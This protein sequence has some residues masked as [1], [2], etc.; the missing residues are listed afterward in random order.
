M[1]E[2]VFMVQMI[3]FR[4]LKEDLAGRHRDRPAVHHTWLAGAVVNNLFGSHP[5]DP[6]VAD[7]A[8]HNRELVEEELRGLAERCPDLAPF[9]TD[10]LRMQTICDNQEG[11][12]S[13]PS[14]LMARALGILQEER[15][16]PMP[17][18]F[19]TTVRQLAARHGLVE[20]MQPAAPPENEPS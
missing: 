5:S 15:P 6:E 9:L 17:S 13:I 16:L 11:I 14:L 19:M 18:T 8:R 20:P 2:A 7:F 10:A 4:T 1:R 12:H 3:L